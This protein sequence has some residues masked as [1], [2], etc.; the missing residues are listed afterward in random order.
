MTGPRNFM[1]TIFLQQRKERWELRG[2]EREGDKCYFQ[3]MS[4][5]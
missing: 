2:G 1:E 3:T 4:M 5:K